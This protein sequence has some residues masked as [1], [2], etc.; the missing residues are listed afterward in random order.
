MIVRVNTDKFPA[1]TVSHPAVLHPIPLY[2]ENK[3][4]QDMK[5]TNFMHEIKC[6]QLTVLPIICKI[7]IFSHRMKVD[8]CNQHQVYT[9]A[10][11]C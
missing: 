9:H 1:N 7:E 2:S 8:R 4:A 10:E 5:I 6:Q 11:I 3:V